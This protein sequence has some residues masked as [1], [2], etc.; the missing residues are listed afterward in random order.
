MLHFKGILNLYY[1]HIVTIRVVCNLMLTIENI[2][3]PNYY[4]ALELI[5]VVLYVMQKSRYGKVLILG[6]NVSLVL[7]KYIT[8]SITFKYY[9]APLKL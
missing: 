3:Y 7:D 8:Y 6:Q 9:F 2:K 5:T 1:N 4:M